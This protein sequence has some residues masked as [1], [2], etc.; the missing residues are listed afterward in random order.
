VLPGEGFV[1]YIHGREAEW[2]SICPTLELLPWTDVVFDFKD[3]QA[4]IVRDMAKYVNALDERTRTGALARELALMNALVSPDEHDEHT[5]EQVRWFSS[6][7]RQE[8]RHHLLAH[9]NKDCLWMRVRPFDVWQ[10]R[11]RITGPWSID[12]T[13]TD[14]RAQSLAAIPA[15]WL[16]I[17]AWDKAL[18]RAQHST[19]RGADTLD[20]LESRFIAHPL[21]GFIA[22]KDTRLIAFASCERPGCPCREDQEI[23]EIRSQQL[24]HYIYLMLGTLAYLTQ[25]DEYLVEVTPQAPRLSVDKQK[26]HEK[27]PSLREDLP[28]FILLDPARVAEYGHPSAQKPGQKGSHAS[29][30]PHTRRGH[31]AMLRHERFARDD[32]GRPRRV[33]RKQAWVG[34]TEWT[35]GLHQRYRVLLPGTSVVPALAALR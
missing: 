6:P 17:E 20:N 8:R 13:S 16:C 18:V 4:A 31:W 30:H 34:A 12:L 33:W 26:Q 14:A 5:D 1:D 27:K 7:Y 24:K 11:Q 15:D 32:E 29:P 35:D 2:Q 19:R 10:Q 23:E 9:L 21:Q 22:R 28:H 25:S 3:G